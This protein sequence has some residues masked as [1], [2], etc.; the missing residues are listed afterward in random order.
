M[1]TPKPITIVGGGL[2][3]LTLGIGLRQA[4]IP[5]SAGVSLLVSAGL[6]KHSTLIIGGYTGLLHLAVAMDKRVVML[7]FP[8]N[9]HPFQHPDWAVTQTNGQPLDTITPDAV[10]EACNRAFTALGVR[11]RC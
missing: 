10:N 3:G 6:M 1:P 4:G 11:G 8:G 2:A 5:V 7:N 9:A